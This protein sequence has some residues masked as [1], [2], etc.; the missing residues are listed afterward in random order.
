MQSA[1]T[2][3]SHEHA[4][5]LISGLQHSIVVGETAKDKSRNV[6]NPSALL[7]GECSLKHRDF[8]LSRWGIW[9]VQT[10][11]CKFT[12]V[13][14]FIDESSHTV[15]PGH[16]LII[17]IHFPLIICLFLLSEIYERK[18]HAEANN[19]QQNSPTV[20]CQYSEDNGTQKQFRTFSAVN[21]HFFLGGGSVRLNLTD[22]VKT[23]P[24]IDGQIPWRR[25]RCFELMNTNIDVFIREDN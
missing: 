21:G 10:K 11:S 14:Q 19:C 8:Q 23:Q 4:L 5:V 2:Q 20:L 12:Y 1:H 13:G 7:A 6:S 15:P 25:Q 24:L 22:S 18:L 9:R 3:N 17:F 16:R